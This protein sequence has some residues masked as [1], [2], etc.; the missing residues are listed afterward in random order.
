[1]SENG[2]F[3]QSE[4]G[5]F[6]QSQNLERG[7]GGAAPSTGNFFCCT[8][9]RILGVSPIPNKPS[10]DIWSVVGTTGQVNNI[11]SWLAPQ[12]VTG[13]IYDV[14]TVVLGFEKLGTVLYLIVLEEKHHV[15]ALYDLYIWRIG[16]DGS[17]LGRSYYVQDQGFVDN[18]TRVPVGI[19]RG[20]QQDGDEEPAT[21]NLLLSMAD[22]KDLQISGPPQTNPI[23]IDTLTPPLIDP[24]RAT[25]DANPMPYAGRNR[26]ARFTSYNRDSVEGAGVRYFYSAPNVNAVQGTVLWAESIAVIGGNNVKMNEEAGQVFGVSAV[27]ADVVAAAS[28]NPLG[29]RAFTGLSGF[30]FFDTAVQANSTLVATYYQV[31]ST[32][33]AFGNWFAAARDDSLGVRQWLTGP[34]HSPQSPGQNSTGLGALTHSEVPPD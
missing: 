5:A 23:S 18:L 9:A 20:L 19:G 10:I 4:N 31:A 27:V 11:F 17:D 3:L 32:Q 24:L 6:T 12:P 25:Y 33:G 28:L 7:P 30:D 2:A 16:T 34:V 8:Q 13:G 15:S 22:F 14:D 21:E 29:T 1:M 26:Y